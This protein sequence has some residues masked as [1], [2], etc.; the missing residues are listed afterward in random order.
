[1]PVVLV[2]KKPLEILGGEAIEV[3]RMEE[4]PV[5]GMNTVSIADHLASLIILLAQQPTQVGNRS[6]RGFSHVDSLPEVACRVLSLAAGD[7]S[8]VRPICIPRL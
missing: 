5:L 6:G 7:R 2:T 1:V 3:V 4:S 8:R